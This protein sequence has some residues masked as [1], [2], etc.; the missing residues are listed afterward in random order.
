MFCTN[1]TW[2]RIEREGIYYGQC[3]EL[4]GK[5]H[6]FMPIEIHAVSKATFAEWVAAKGGQMPDVTAAADTAAPEES[7]SET[8]ADEAPDAPVATE[9]ETEAATEDVAP[10]AATDAA[11]DA[12][13][14]T[15]TDAD[16]EPQPAE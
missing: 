16:A 13:A 7:T 4:C 15:A 2:T 11:A 12:A 9:A 8:V 1:E 14:E 6:G 10:E 3:S 5:D